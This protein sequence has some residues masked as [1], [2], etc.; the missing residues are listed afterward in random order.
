MATDKQEET[1]IRCGT[2]IVSETHSGFIYFYIY[3]EENLR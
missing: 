3:V 2:E 1:L